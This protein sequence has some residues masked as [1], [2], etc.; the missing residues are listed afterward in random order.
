MRNA[1]AFIIVILLFGCRYQPSTPI[2]IAVSHGD[3][4]EMSRLLAAGADPNAF[5]GAGFTPL[6]LAA[7]AGDSK[8]IKLLVSHGANVNLADH[9]R[10]H[11][12]PLLHAT[13]KKQIDAVRELLAAG[14]DVNATDPRKT[15]A[16][17]MAAGYGD[18]AIV[19]V[20]LS[21]GADKK[22]VNAKGETALDLAKS[23]VT[24]IDHLTL[25]HDQ[26]DTVAAL[27]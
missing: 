12:P 11:W 19:N 21:C 27:K 9:A 2:M 3:T 4:A 25:Y 13:H 15:T 16:L 7:R 20:L 1:L 8:A 24:D 26:S 6:I 18:T 10:N 17:M 22:R 23:G 14:A 5:D